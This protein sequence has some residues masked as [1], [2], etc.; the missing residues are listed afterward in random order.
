[1]IVS[2][3][4]LA[5]RLTEAEASL[6]LGERRTKSE[7]FE[8][9]PDQRISTKFRPKMFWEEFGRCCRQNFPS[10]KKFQMFQNSKVENASKS[11]KF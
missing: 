5:M 7:E 1:M 11:S 9:G 8:N 3:S 2:D 4:V 6:C 10:L